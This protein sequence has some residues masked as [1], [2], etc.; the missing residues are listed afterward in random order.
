MVQPRVVGAK[1]GESSQPVRGRNIELRVLAE[2]LDQLLSGVGTVVLV[3]GDTGMGKSR[4]LGEVGTMARRLSIRVGS[5]AADLGDSVVQMSVLMEA[6]FD[7]P[8]PI[9]ERA[10]LRDA[11]TSPE[12]RYGCCRTSRHYSSVPRSRRRC[13]CV[14]MTSSGPIAGRRR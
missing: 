9:L 14:S 5:G 10:A 11:H 6:L 4:L 7:G 8:S 13:W 1:A 2:H 3:E 12:Q